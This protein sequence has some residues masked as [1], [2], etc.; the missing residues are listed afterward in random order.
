[1]NQTAT[2]C[3]EQKT[4]VRFKQDLSGGIVARLRQSDNKTMLALAERV[5]RCANPNNVFVAD[6]FHTGDGESYQANGSLWACSSLVCQNCV[7][8]LARDNRK[9]IR[10]VMTNEKLLTGEDWYCITPTMPDA[11]LFGYSLDFIG[12]VYQKAFEAFTHR[13][14][15]EKKWTPYQKLIRGL[16]KNC[17]FTTR[18]NNTFHFHS[19]LLAIA[20]KKIKDDDFY[21]IRQLWTR[22]VKKAFEY[23]GIDFVCRTSDKKFKAAMFLFRHVPEMRAYFLLCMLDRSRFFGLVNVNV[24]QVDFSNREKTILELSKYVTKSDSWEKISLSEIEKIVERPRRARMFEALGVC[25]DSARKMREEAKGSR[26]SANE[27]QAEIETGADTGTYIY[28]KQLTPRKLLRR[29]SSWRARI[30]VMTLAEYRFEL[31]TEISRAQ[32]FRR[33]QLRHRFPCA[34]FETLDGV[35]WF[36]VTAEAERASFSSIADY[37]WKDSTSDNADTSLIH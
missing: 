9:T 31:E 23:Y 14:R 26:N 12:A 5:E 30:K 7:G 1:M 18:E 16:F 28:T 3:P 19:H 29:K 24:E 21:Q 33:Q 11:L 17:E 36:G 32:A 27:S 13:N 8:R 22:A 20:K 6:D 25:R 4:R 2:F 34:T 37:R 35:R 10:Y 15:D